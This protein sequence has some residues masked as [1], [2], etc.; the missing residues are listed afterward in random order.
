MKTYIYT[1]KQQSKISGYDE[2]LVN[3][4]EIMVEDLETQQWIETR[5]DFE[6]A[7]AKKKKERAPKEELKVEEVVEE[8]PSEENGD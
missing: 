8:T 1:G 5:S 4:S 2:I 3:G 6:L 7:G